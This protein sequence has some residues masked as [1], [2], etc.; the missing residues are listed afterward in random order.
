MPDE[1]NALVAIL[2]G[3]ALI[4]LFFVDAQAW[5]I[6]TVDSSCTKS[7]FNRTGTS[8]GGWN[9]DSGQILQR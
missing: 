6:Q 8:C 1:E 9:E 5:G 4:C 3:V 2:L 7:R